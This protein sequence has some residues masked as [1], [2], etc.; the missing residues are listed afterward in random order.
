MPKIKSKLSSNHS[1]KPSK[2]LTKLSGP[3]S[4]KHNRNPRHPYDE[5]TA[6]GN[7][8]ELGEQ[9]HAQNRSSSVVKDGCYPSLQTTICVDETRPADSIHIEGG[10]LG[11]NIMKTVRME[12]SG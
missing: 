6:T 8:L 4:L 12:T 1:N 9:D 5:Y 3:T 10:S 11:P 2:Y 7:Y